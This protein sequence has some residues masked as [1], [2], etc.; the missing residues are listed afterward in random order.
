MNVG[1]EK[2]MKNVPEKKKMVSTS[3]VKYVV[4]ATVTPDYEYGFH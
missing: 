4:N 1:E 2:E 3:K